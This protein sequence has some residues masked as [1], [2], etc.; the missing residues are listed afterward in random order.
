M[1]KPDKQKAIPAATISLLGS[2]P[3]EFDLP[4]SLQKLD[5]E[6]LEFSMRA[7]SMKKSEWAAIRDERQRAILQAAK[8]PE[9]DDTET[10]V[11]DKALAML[12]TRGQVAASKANAVRDAE[13]IMKFAVSWPAEQKLCAETLAELED[14]LA[15]S[16]EGII[17]EYDSAIFR[18]RLGNSRT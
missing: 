3:A 15:G 18:G 4:V 2:Q 16:L 14:E 5:G 10:S 17:L 8:P 9:D 11:I 1:T 6:V 7:K 13:V 12:E